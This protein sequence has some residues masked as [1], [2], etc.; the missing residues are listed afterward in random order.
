MKL[1]FFRSGGLQN[2][3]KTQQ[4]INNVNYEY[5]NYAS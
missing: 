4:C 2:G 1:V 3:S 5:N